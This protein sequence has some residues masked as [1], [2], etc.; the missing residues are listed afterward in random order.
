MYVAVLQ[1]YQKE[2]LTDGFA[3]TVDLIWF[4]GGL[5]GDA[6]GMTDRTFHNR[7]KELI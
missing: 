2:K 5:N 1:A 7:L 3:D 6:L 4:Y